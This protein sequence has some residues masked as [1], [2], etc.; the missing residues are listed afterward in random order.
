M[1]SYDRLFHEIGIPEFWIDLTSDTRGIRELRHQRL[2]RAI[3]VVYRPDTE[4]RSHYFHARLADEFDAMIH[5]DRTRAVTPL[6]SAATW[7][8]SEA[9]EA[10]P[11]GL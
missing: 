3:G 7:D 5:I 11:A 9:P 4:R 6:D 10:F 2:Q 8:R 1:N